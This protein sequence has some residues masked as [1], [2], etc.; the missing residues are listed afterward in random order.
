MD[1]PARRWPPLPA[2]SWRKRARWLAPR[3]PCAT[4]AVEHPHQGGGPVGD[5]PVDPEP[6]EPFHLRLLLD[7]P[8]VD[9]HAL[10]V[11]HIDELLVDQRHVAVGD[12]NLERH[13]AHGRWLL[14]GP[15]RL[16][17]GGGGRRAR[18]R[19]HL[20]GE[21]REGR[22]GAVAAVSYTHLTLPT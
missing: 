13:V 8:H 12:R 7:G 10:P 1:G 19:G 6:T 22:G 15:D 14:P 3:V 4:E 18:R 17:E 9:G 21:R 2:P 16:V 11:G 5:D 20:G